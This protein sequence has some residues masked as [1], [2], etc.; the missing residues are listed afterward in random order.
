M[1]NYA[2]ETNMETL[3]P[4]IMEGGIADFEDQL[5]EASRRVDRD[6]LEWYRRESERR[7][8][9]SEDYPFDR[10]LVDD[11]DVTVLCAMK[12]I[13]LAAEVLTSHDPDGDVWSQ[14]R[15]HYADE[16]AKELKQILLVGVEYDWDESGTVES[17]ELPVRRRRRLK[18]A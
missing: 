13:E 18:R 3:C 8:V 2:T 5:T 17:D 15:D 7:G 11:D 1:A 10:D 6:L 16:Y 4:Q 12:G 14:I 9:D